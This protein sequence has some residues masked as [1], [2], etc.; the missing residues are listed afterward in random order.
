MQE[1]F[2]RAYDALDGLDHPDRFGAW[3]FRILTNQCHN[4]RDRHR[5]HASLETVDVAGGD[6]PERYLEVEEARRLVNR[7]LDQLTPELRET[8]VL[9]E[10]EGRPYAEISELLAATEPALRKRVERA[11]DLVRDFVKEQG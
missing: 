8:F 2:I 11:R 10:I 4:V 9:R 5:R 1:A 3:F 7:A 6:T